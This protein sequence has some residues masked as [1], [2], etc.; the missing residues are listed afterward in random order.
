MEAYPFPNIEDDEVLRVLL[1]IRDM[2]QGTELNRMLE[3]V[4]L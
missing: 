1:L 4:Y 3:R 2:Y